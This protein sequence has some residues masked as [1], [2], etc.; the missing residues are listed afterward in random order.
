MT[1]AD[2]LAR[3][4]A[5]YEALQKLNSDELSFY[6]YEEQFTQLWTELGREVMEEN[7]GTGT[8][9]KKNAATPATD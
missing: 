8:G 1:K 4:E 5:R 6:A 9:R 3:A 7:L 2:F